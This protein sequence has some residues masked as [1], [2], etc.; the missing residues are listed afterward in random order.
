M[1]VGKRA[2]YLELDP[3]DLHLLV[4]GPVQTVDV[5]EADAGAAEEVDAAAVGV[6]AAVPPPH[7]PPAT[8][9]GPEAEPPALAEVAEEVE[10]GETGGGGAGGGHFGGV[11]RTDGDF[12]SFQKGDFRRMKRR[13]GDSRAVRSS[14]SPSLRSRL[15]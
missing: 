3:D 10:G 12:V 13:R 8:S 7:P 2:A 1:Q 11:R 15:F 6:A 14:G 9:V 4:D 5:V